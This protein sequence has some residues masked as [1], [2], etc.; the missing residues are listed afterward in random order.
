MVQSIESAMFT[1]L[2]LEFCQL[3]NVCGV[4]DCFPPVPRAGV[5]SYFAGA[6]E[7][8]DPLKIGQDNQLPAHLRCRHLVVVQVEAHVR[9][10]S[11]TDRDS[12]VTTE[13]V[14]R[15]LQELGVLLLVGLT[16]CH[17]LV[18]WTTSI[19]GLTQAPGVSLVVEVIEI[20]KLAPREEAGAD[21][22]NRSL[23]PTLLVTASYSN[24]A[25]LIAIMSCQLQ[26]SRV[27]SNSIA[28]ALEHRTIQIVVEQDSGDASKK[29]ECRNM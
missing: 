29:F 10:F 15:Q 24:R 20:G 1:G 28:A 7:D 5:A 21:V 18:L 22:A 16:H 2:T 23:D 13:G 3:L 9:C 14:A 11:N 19:T 17:A 25:Q 12:L 26:Q 6:I 27:E 8:A 4:L